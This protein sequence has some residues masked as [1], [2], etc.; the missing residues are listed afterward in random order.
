[1]H[2]RC[3]NC[4]RLFTGKDLAKQATRGMEEERKSLGLE[5]V[6]FR[7]YD[8]PACGQADIFV[9]VHPLPDEAPADFLERRRALEE[10]VRGLHAEHV[11][12]VLTAR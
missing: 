4:R 12:V 7:S 10:A 3:T 5:G 11:E 2:R 6:A 9:D 8:C 1:M